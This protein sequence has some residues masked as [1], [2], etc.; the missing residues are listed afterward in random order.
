MWKYLQFYLI[1]VAIKKTEESLSPICE[2]DENIWKAV[3]FLE[4]FCELKRTE[5]MMLNIS[6]YQNVDEYIF[7][8]H[9]FITATSE[10]FFSCLNDIEPYFDLPN[11]VFKSDPLKIVQYDENGVLICDENLIPPANSGRFTLT[12]LLIHGFLGSIQL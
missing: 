1:F 12:N 5:N 6:V 11:Q 9:K 7:H 8:T 10:K 2:S 3:S 4:E